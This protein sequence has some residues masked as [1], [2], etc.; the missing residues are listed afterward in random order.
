MCER[1]NE[2]TNNQQLVVST[3]VGQ[4]L[5][6]APNEL[7]FSRWFFKIYNHGTKNQRTDSNQPFFFLG[8]K[9]HIIANFF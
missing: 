2:P 1:N 3:G 5:E 7:W 4:F 6:M 8:V 9:S